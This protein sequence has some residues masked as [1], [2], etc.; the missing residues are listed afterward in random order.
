M[1]TYT[2]GHDE[3][4]PEGVYDFMVVDA[5]ERESQKKADGTGGNPMIELEM[6]IKGPSGKN[7][8]RVFDH[9][10]FTPKSFWKIDAFRLATGEKLVEGQTVSFEAED[11]IDRAGK[12]WLTVE[13]Y[14]GRDRNRVGEYLD[15]SAENPPPSTAPKKEPRPLSDELG[16]DEIPMK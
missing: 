2:M 14:Q 10:V 8:L 15:P 3:T 13:S 9:L 5:T 12:V 4:L 1:P 7:A 11:C 6:M 16:D